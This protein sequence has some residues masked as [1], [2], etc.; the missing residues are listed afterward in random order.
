MDFWIVEVFFKDNRKKPYENSKKFQTYILCY[1]LARQDFH[2]EKANS[3]SLSLPLVC[4]EK[5]QELV[6][7]V[8]T[9]FLNY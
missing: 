2:C 3:C 5:Y 1:V 6:N 4:A 8:V 9:F 7:I